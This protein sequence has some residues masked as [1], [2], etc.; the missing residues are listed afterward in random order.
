MFV[1]FENEIFDVFQRTENTKLNK[2]VEQLI[3]EVSLLES[4][5]GKGEFNPTTTKVIRIESNLECDFKV[6]H[7]SINP[8][9]QVYGKKTVPIDL[10]AMDK[11]K[12]ENEALAAQIA[13]L[14]SRAPTISE[15]DEKAQEN[16]KLKKQLTDAEKRTNRLK[17][18]I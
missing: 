9:S 17:E 3:R 6:L 7:M 1:C 14:K 15:N 10:E 16:E 11:L 4:R 18:V 8:A 5:V 2:E 12:K 13:E